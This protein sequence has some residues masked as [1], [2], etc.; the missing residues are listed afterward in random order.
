MN[1][2]WYLKIITAFLLVILVVIIPTAFYLE[3]T[4]NRFLMNQKEDELRRE[5]RLAAQMIS[6]RSESSSMDMA[7]AQEIVRQVESALQKRATFISADGRVLGDSRLTPAMVDKLEDHSHRP[8]IIAAKEKGYGQTIRFSTTLQ[9]NALYGALPIYQNH[10]LVGF[11]RLALPLSRL[12][13]LLSDLRWTLLLAGG[14]TSILALMLSFFL[15]WSINRPLREVTVMV[16]K[17]AEGDLNQPFHLLPK[18]EFSDLIASLERMAGELKEKM[19]LL[20]AETSQLTTLLSKMHEGVL[21]TDEKGRIILMNPFLREIL[22]DK[23]VWRKRSVQ[24]IFMNSD[25]QDAVESVLQKES[26][27]HLELTYG[28][29]PQKH[30]DVQVVA[31]NPTQRARRAVALFHDVT[32]LQYLIKVRQDFVANASHELRTP[33][34]SISGYV[35]TLLT[36][37]PPEPAEIQ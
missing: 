1:F 17:M 19:D 31:L 5:L 4:L 14:L 35:E 27:K 24:E 7:K 23:V 30:F 10:K 34:T 25:L 8:E 22:G 3:S 37:V 29:A 2:R 9:S 18:S 6:G 21:L 32:E 11:I 20:E 26:F 28:R 13:Q 15:T 36:L 12:E 33:L 16:K